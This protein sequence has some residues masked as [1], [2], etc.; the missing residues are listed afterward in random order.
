MFPSASIYNTFNG[1]QGHVIL[2][3]KAWQRMTSG[4]Q[5]SN[6]KNIRLAQLCTMV[7]LTTGAGFG[8][9]GISI[10]NATGGALRM[11]LKHLSAFCRHVACIVRVCAKPQ[12]FRVHARRIVATMQHVQSFRDF[13]VMQ[14]PRDTMCQF[15]SPIMRDAPI[16]MFV[17]T[18]CPQPTVIRFVNIGPKA[19]LSWTR[20]CIA[21]AAFATK[22]FGVVQWLKELTALDA[23][24]LRAPEVGC[25]IITHVGTP[26]RAT[27]HAPGCLQQRGGFVLSSN[28]TKV[29]ALAQ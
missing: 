10:L 17:A 4:T 2:N 6:L 8:M 25:G 23:G 9:R 16:A 12:M 22:L 21:I 3:S 28:Y 14:Y 18:S 26:N 15:H 24:S 7:L 5:F 1:S 13:A 20:L 11:F 29:C 27:G 19:I